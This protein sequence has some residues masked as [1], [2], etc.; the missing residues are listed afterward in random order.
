V[1][2][3]TLAVAMAAACALAMFVGVSTAS[4]PSAKPTGTAAAVGGNV[5]IRFAIQKFV[6]QGSKLVA[7]GSV[8]GTYTPADGTTP[9]TVTS[10]FTATV[11]TGGRS[12]ASASRIC[13][14]LH[15]ELG[16]LDL[17]LLGLMVHLDKVVLDIKANSNGGILGSL[18][19]SLSKA[20]LGRRA[21]SSAA[22][23]LTSAARS[24]QLGSGVGFAVPVS[25]QSSTQTATTCSILD[26]TLGPLDLN[27]LGLMVHLDTVHLTITAQKGG[28]VLGDLLCSVAGATV[29]AIP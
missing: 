13:Q 2:R 27:V 19:C 1:R 20:K 28:G 9:T 3:F 10:P 14:V 22:H 15:L 6:R 4:A 16:P 12:L 24:S 21:L 29:P 11:V 25:A 26:L 5:Q 18:F 8:I 23:R 17:N 7:K